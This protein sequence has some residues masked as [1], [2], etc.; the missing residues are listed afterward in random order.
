[1]LHKDGRLTG[2]TVILGGIDLLVCTCSHSQPRQ[3]LCLSRKLMV[4]VGSVALPVRQANSHNTWLRYLGVFYSQFH[5]IHDLQGN[6]PWV[7]GA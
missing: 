1:M 3:E 5:L 4:L 7:L 2:R 6:C